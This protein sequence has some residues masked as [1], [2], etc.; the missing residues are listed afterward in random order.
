MMILS[1]NKGISNYYEV[2]DVE[3]SGNYEEKMLIYNHM[4]YLPEVEIRTLDNNKSMY[5]K[6]DGFSPLSNIYGR[7]VPTMQDVMGLVGDIKNCI[8]E[9]REYLLNPACLVLNLK[10]ILYDEQTR[11][12]K[13]IYIPNTIRG[14][15]DQIKQM[16]EEIMRIFD[17][18][19]RDGVVFLYEMYSRFL[20]DNFSPDIF[21]KVVEEFEGRFVEEKDNVIEGDNSFFSDSD[22]TYAE[23]DF[24]EQ[25][26]FYMLASA[27]AVIT[28]IVLLIIFGPKSFKF[29]AVIIAALII[30]IITDYYHLKSKERR[31]DIQIIEEGNEAEKTAVKHYEKKVAPQYEK[32][33]AAQYDKRFDKQIDE[34]FEIHSEPAPDSWTDSTTVLSNDEEEGVSKLIPCD[35][36]SKDQIFLIEGETKI[37][38]QTSVCDYCINE[39]SISR[40]HAIIEKIGNK[41]LIRDAGSTNGTYINDTRLEEN[42]P[43]EAVSGDMISFAGVRYECR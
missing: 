23:D 28:S 4:N 31:P 36:G 14:F 25:K 26:S 20:V 33:V 9:I 12:H 27:A 17:H 8:K 21:C 29:S 1:R 30:Y 3:L 19:N 5:V 32:R 10:Y 43:V 37:G 2:C 38:R 15:K 7:C 34:Q 42:R 13:F 24:K 40:V 39:P 16:F 41:L 22:Y 18:K 35:E 11:T 6:V